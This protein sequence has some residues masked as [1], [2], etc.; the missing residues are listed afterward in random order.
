MLK[1][2]ETCHG[3]EL[4]EALPV[5]LA[6]VLK[7]DLEPVLATGRQLRRGERHPHAV[8]AALPG[9]GKQRTPAATEV[10]QAAPRPD[11]DLLG[12]VLVLAPLRLLE[13]QREI[14]V[15]LRAA[16]IGQLTETEPDDP[17]G[18][19]VGEVGVPTD[20][21]PTNIRLPVRGPEDDAHDRVLDRAIRSGPEPWYPRELCRA[22]KA[23]RHSSP[24]CGAGLGARTRRSSLA[25]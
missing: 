22:G 9:V 17:I 13:I 10:E 11:P 20:R 7:I 5:D 19:R 8:P 16:E 12:H 14:P 23:L 21:H 24:Q 18:Q 25:S 4:A 6:R 1:R 2:A 15:E 3:F